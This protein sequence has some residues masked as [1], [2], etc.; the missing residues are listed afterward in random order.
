MIGEKCGVGGHDFMSNRDLLDVKVNLPRCLMM[1][2][3]LIF[4]QFT[5]GSMVWAKLKGFPW[6]PGMVDYCPD[7]QVTIVYYIDQHFK[8]NPQEY[9]WIEED[10][11]V[12]E[13]T[14][15]NV[16]YF[17]GRGDEVKSI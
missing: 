1:V 4:P 12:T 2:V 6:W 16:V 8:A 9:Y 11:S 15:Y 13:P 7:S 3:D 10:V 17:E 14:Y 5:C